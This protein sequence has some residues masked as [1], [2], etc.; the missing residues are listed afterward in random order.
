MEKEIEG[1]NL[2][3]GKEEGLLLSIDLGFQRPTCEYYLV[4]SFF[5]ASV[6]HFSAMK[7]TMANLWHPLKGVQILD[8]GTR[9][10]L[11]RFFYEMDTDR[12]TKGTPWTF[13]NHLLIF[14][15]LENGEDPMQVPLVSM[16]FW[17]QVHEL[18]PCFFLEV[19]AKQLGNFIGSHND[20]FCLVR[21]DRREENLVFGRSISLKA[22]TKGANIETSV[23]LREEGDDTFSKISLKKPESKRNSKDD[24]GSDL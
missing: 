12:V 20:K 1:L 21:L 8:L 5:T 16:T 15:R 13:N 19:V 23:W 22:Q 2:E 11:F 10:Y 7:N 4:G 6:V 3:D 9:R 24:W 14:H 18:P 17:V